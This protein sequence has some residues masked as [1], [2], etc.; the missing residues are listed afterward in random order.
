MLNDLAKQ[1]LLR[2]SSPTFTQACWLPAYLADQLTKV[3]ELKTSTFGKVMQTSLFRPPMSPLANNI[4]KNLY[5]SNF[6]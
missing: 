3:R 2:L 6:S 5:I 1:G 4:K